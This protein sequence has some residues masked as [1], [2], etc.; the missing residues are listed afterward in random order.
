M[1]KKIKSAGYNDTQISEIIGTVALNI[2]TNYFNSDFGS[3]IK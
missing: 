1:F 3:N 2:L